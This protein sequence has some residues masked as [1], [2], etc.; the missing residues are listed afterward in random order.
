MAWGLLTKGVAAEARCATWFV[1]STKTLHPVIL[2]GGHGQAPLYR[3]DVTSA[4]QGQFLR[5]ISRL[6][7]SALK[8]SILSLYGIEDLHCSLPISSQL[9]QAD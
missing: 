1:G 6:R 3:L 5:K 4:V 7:V 2:Q 9:I 8:H